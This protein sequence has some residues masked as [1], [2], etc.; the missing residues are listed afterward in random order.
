M[1]KA[2]DV[3]LRVAQSELAVKMTLKLF[4]LGEY[5]LID[6]VFDACFNLIS[7]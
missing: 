7:S 2:L 3:K 5:G 4:A 6:R 1:I